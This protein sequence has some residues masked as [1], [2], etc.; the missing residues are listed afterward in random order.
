MAQLQS[1]SL[2]CC[3]LQRKQHASQLQLVGVHAQRVSCLCSICSMA[4][5]A[6]RACPT[7]GAGKPEAADC[8][9]ITTSSRGGHSIASSSC[10]RRP[11]RLAQCAM[12][13]SETW[14]VSAGDQKHHYQA[15]T[16]GRH[17]MQIDGCTPEPKAVVCHV[18]MSGFVTCDNVKVI[19]TMHC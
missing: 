3:L 8:Q 13:R 12:P 16:F 10:H 19:A 6:E 15:T 4:P 14:G 1:E 9:Q 17:R 7:A 5:L 11:S 2:C 18:T